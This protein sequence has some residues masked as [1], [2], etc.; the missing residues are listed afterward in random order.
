[1]NIGLKISLLVWGLM[2]SYG[3]KSQTIDLKIKQIRNTKGQICV[4]IFTGQTGFDT[5][6]PGW[7]FRCPKSTA[8][9]GEIDMHISLRPGQYGVA[10]LDD[11]DYT[12]RMEYN[13]LGMPLKGFGFGGYDFSGFR[14]PAFSKFCFDIGENEV[15]SLVVNMKYFF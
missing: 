14:K 3:L 2:M 12:C 15:K 10:V 13:F 4:A 6:N 1:M 8:I 7:Q 5:C 9:R 11:E